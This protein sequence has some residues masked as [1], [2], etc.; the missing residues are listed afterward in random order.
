MEDKRQMYCERCRKAVLI[1]NIKYVPK[2][3]GTKI[4][5]CTD[6]LAKTHA[7]IG[8][9]RPIPKSKKRSSYRCLRCKY[10]FKLDTTGETNLKCPFCGKDD[11]VIED[12][13]TVEKLIKEVDDEDFVRFH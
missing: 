3:D 11:K 2:P 13:I 1:A 7:Y 5:L 10:S 12:N 6:C 4:S 8:Q 9:N